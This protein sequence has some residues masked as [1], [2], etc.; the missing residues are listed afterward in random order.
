MPSELLP[1][2]LLQILIVG[3]T[4]GPANIYALTMALRYGRRRAL[5]MWTG[6]FAGA[7]VAVS[8]V[9]VALHFAGE[10]FGDYVEWLKYLGAAYLLYLAWK[11]WRDAK[12]ARSAG[13][14]GGDDV[15]DAAGGNVGGDAADAVGGGVSA[16]A[17]NNACDAAEGRAGGWAE[18]GDGR[19]QNSP[20]GEAGNCQAGGAEASPADGGAALKA[21][22]KAAGGK[23]ECSF[24]SGFI[25]QMTNAKI[26]LFDLTVFGSFVLPWSDSLADLFRV[27]ALLLI[28]GPGANIVWLLVGGYL[29]RFI[30]H[31]LRTV[32]IVSAIA[33][34]LCAVYVVLP[35]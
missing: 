17:G 3:Y 14:A 26:I 4:P 2:L 30:S 31:N 1:T 27:A 34:V 20:A 24:V 8:I 22:G 5:R 16:V 6:M 15:A 9:A 10:T 11:M 13:D 25:M 18:N 23:N 7:A 12:P 28:A 21:A 19:R 32:D 29:S 33:L 35:R